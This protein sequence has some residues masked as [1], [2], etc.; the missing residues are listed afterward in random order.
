MGR[1]K[2]GKDDA[3]MGART[4]LLD[5][6]GEKLKLDTGSLSPSTLF[7]FLTYVILILFI[8]ISLEM[9]KPFPG[10]RYTMY[11]SYTNTQIA[12]GQESS[13]QQFLLRF[14]LIPVTSEG[15]QVSV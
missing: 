10:G 12:F 7:P 15:E 5:F 2:A 9:L 3:C 8:K 11:T 4:G 13:V 14:L 6:G 1:G